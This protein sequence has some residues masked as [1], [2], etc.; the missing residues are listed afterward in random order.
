M[1][2]IL[3][4]WGINDLGRLYESSAC[5]FHSFLPHIRRTSWGTTKGTLRNEHMG[6]RFL[7]VD[8]GY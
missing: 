8:M 3:N 7:I 6:T 2:R 5:E 1:L 4:V